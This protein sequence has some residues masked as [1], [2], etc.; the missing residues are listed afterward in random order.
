M[1]QGEDCLELEGKT[2][3]E[4]LKGRMEGNIRLKREIN[5]HSLTLKSHLQ[6]LAQGML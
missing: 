2:K 4:Y 5:P 3:A 6:M 1:K